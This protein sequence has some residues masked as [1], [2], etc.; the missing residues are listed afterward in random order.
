[1]LK[2]SVNG[3]KMLLPVEHLVEI[4]SVPVGQVVPMFNL[5]MWISGVYN[6]RGEILWIVDLGHLL[7]LT[8]WYQQTGYGAKHTVVVL[9]RPH[10]QKLRR[11]ERS[12]LGLVVNLA[13]GMTAGDLESLRSNPTAAHQQVLTKAASFIRGYLPTDDVPVLNGEAVLAAMP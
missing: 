2:I 11:E 10:S 6:W 4:L 3:V 1:M 12:P 7:G 13:D 5:P 9:D 8:P